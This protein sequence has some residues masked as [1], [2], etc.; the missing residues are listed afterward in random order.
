MNQRITQ[1]LQWLETDAN[2]TFLL[3]AVAMEYKN[4]DIPK[5][6]EYFE[7][8]LTSHEDYLP[9]YY[10]VAEIYVELKETEKAEMIYKKGIQLAQQQKQ[11][12]TLAELQSAYNNFLYE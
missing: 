4:F 3:Y 2:D 1:L 8:L 5:A 11:Q 7:K 9:T 6:L 10:Q 12:K